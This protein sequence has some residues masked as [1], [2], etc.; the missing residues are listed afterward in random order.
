LPNKQQLVDSEFTRQ[1]YTV[2]KIFYFGL[3]KFSWNI[4]EVQI[5]IIFFLHFW[6]PIIKKIVVTA[7]I[8]GSVAEGLA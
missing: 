4:A 6:P 1:Q 8:F 2:H 3:R 7:T 5:L